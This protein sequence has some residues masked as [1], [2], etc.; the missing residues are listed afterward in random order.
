MVILLTAKVSSITNTY[1]RFHIVTPYGQPEK[2]T[3]TKQKFVKGQNVRIDKFLWLDLDDRKTIR[4]SPVHQFIEARIS[5][6]RLTGNRSDD[7]DHNDYQMY[8]QDYD[9]RYGLRAI[10]KAH[11][12]QSMEHGEDLIVSAY[13]DKFAAGPYDVQLESLSSSSGRGTK[14]KSSPELTIG[15]KRQKK[16]IPLK[17]SKD[18]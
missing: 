5:S 4:Q 15:S 8:D 17:L 10:E 12:S 14:R 18:Q 2:W 16:S 3:Q 7:F 13:Q 1:T 9:Q 11:G 6:A